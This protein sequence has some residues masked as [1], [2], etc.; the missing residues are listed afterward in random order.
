M[1]TAAYWFAPEPD[2]AAGSRLSLDFGVRS[3]DLFFRELVVPEIGRVWYVRQ[4]SWPLAALRIHDEIRAKTRNIPRPSI[5]AN[6]LEALACKV[7]FHAP[8]GA[9]SKRILG[10]RAFGRDPDF[11]IRSFERLQRVDCYVRNTWR[12]AAV[13]AMRGEGGLGFVSGR[14]FD[15]FRL[16]NVGVALADSFLAQRVGKMKLATWLGSWLEGG[17]EP[18]SISSSLVAALSPE[19][20]TA[21]ECSWV[22][23]RLLGTATAAC[24]KRRR[25]RDSLEES[26]TEPDVERDVVPRLHA[27]G[28]AQ[29]AREILAAL[30]FGAM[31]DR[32]IELVAGVT[33]VIEG[34]PRGHAPDVLTEDEDVD[35]ACSRLLESA[36]TFVSRA[37][38]AGVT[39]SSS[40][41]YAHEILTARDPPHLVERVVARSPKLF[42]RAD[43]AVIRGP[44]F[45][46]L[47]GGDGVE[48]EEELPEPDRTGRTFRIA[49]FHA[50]VRDLRT[51]V[52]AN[53]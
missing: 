43:G 11:M 32:S 52:G 14:R 25:L 23:Q 50:L 34:A 33:R 19:T 53:P 39:E 16:E 10:V 17:E 3:A 37:R 1:G 35:R 4:L 26:E 7:A 15:R 9:R 8:H 47:Q 51:H 45:R 18:S 29:Q 28:H 30:G 41:A 12:Q 21:E 49:N 22:D 13:R 42:S 2:D 6:A 46:V 36:R 31:L 40:N 48:D 24:E 44:L 27:A 20:P 5:I 38:E